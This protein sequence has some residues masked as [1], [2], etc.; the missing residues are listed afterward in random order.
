MVSSHRAIN[1]TASSW[2]ELSP[3]VWTL[4]AVHLGAFLLWIVLLVRGAF[5][6]TARK[7]DLKQH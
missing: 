5:S 6:G 3:L 1:P 2:Q 7:G 4:V